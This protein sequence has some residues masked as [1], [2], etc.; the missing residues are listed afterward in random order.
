MT[1]GYWLK[2]KRKAVSITQRDLAYRTGLSSATISHLE[3]KGT[4]PS[5]RTRQKIEAVLGQYT[6]FEV[7]K[8]FRPVK[9][10]FALAKAQGVLVKT[11]K[12]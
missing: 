3:H 9:N 10:D 2:M 7:K 4:P 8:I 11:I 12:C 6:K 5:P 1:F